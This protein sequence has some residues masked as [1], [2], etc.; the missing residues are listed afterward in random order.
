MREIL[1]TSYRDAEE[2]LRKSDLR[3]ALYE[4]SGVMYAKV[5]VNLHG[6]EH[7]LR[8]AVEQ[9]IFRKDVFRFY[10]KNVFPDTVASTLAPFVARGRAD[11]VDLGYRVMLNVTADF[12]GIDRP[13][14]SPQETETLLRLLRN[15]GKAATL[16]QATGDRE[17]IKIEIQNAVDEFE[18]DFYMPSMRRR[19]ALLDDHA[20]GRIGKDE[21]PHD[22]LTVLL[23]NYDRLGASH[24]VL[25]KELA[26][27]LLA[28]A[29]T[30]IHSTTHGMHELFEWT[31]AH[32]RD[33]DLVD[34]DPFFLQRCAME[35]ARLHPSSPV[36]RRRA[37][38]PTTLPNG[39]PVSAADLVTV[40]MLVANRDPAMFGEDAACYN[41]KR[42]VDR[43]TYLPGLSFGVGMHACIGRNLAIGTEPR[44]GT[45]PADHQFGT[46]PLIMRALID[47]KVRPDPD[48]L[49]VM[50]TSTT[51]PNWASYPVLL[52]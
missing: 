34:R 32:P 51:R 3:Q 45:D 11:L 21:V 14:K 16:S 43:L 30:S 4:E 18:R 8:R 44:P 35:S 9:T 27:M 28:G 39:C 2:T 26:F 40:N 38:S 48:N 10:E 15:F 22:I 1:V 25:M 36:A 13:K 46:V 23:Q 29:F 6:D 47:A 5:L 49:P 52:G 24:D 33:R 41:P 42:N 12:S 20:A 17:A 50:D 31:H 7:R 37:T 19:Q